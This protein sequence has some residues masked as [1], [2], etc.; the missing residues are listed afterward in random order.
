MV[1]KEEEGGAEVVVFEQAEIS[2]KSGGEILGV[3]TTLTV[4][5]LLT[6]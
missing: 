1:C 4:F 3:G 5:H 6:I 2:K